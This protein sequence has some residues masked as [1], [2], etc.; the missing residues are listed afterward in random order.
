ML[1]AYKENIYFDYANLLLYNI[2]G[3]PA[4]GADVLR[5]L[6]AESN[7]YQEMQISSTVIIA[8]RDAVNKVRSF[9]FCFTN[10]PFIFCIHG[11]RSKVAL[12][13]IHTTT[14]RS[15]HGGDGDCVC[16]KV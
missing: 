16:Y 1:I 2:Q 11:D 15:S 6:I 14:Q 9:Q 10:I 7:A 13:R 3:Y 8:A 5:W 12:R 4:C